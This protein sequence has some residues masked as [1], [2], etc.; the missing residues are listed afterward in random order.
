MTSPDD[1]VQVTE[2][3]MTRGQ[4]I[5]WSPYEDEILRLYRDEQ[6]SGDLIYKHFIAIGI[7][8]D[9]NWIEKAISY[10]GE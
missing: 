1:A 8:E 10:I 2:Q 4:R 5:D 6:L 9:R 7:D 3:N